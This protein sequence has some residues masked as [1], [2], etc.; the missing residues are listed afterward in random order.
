MAHG[1][2]ASWVGAALWGALL[3]L[4][5]LGIGGRAVMRVI[6]VSA[7]TPPTATFEGTLTVLLAG[8]GS[9]AAAG[10]IYRVLVALLPHRR[11]LRHLAFLLVL[12]G[13][14]LR[15]LRPIQP[16]PLALFGS[17]MAIFAAAFLATWRRV[18]LHHSPVEKSEDTARVYAR[19]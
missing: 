15:G 13:L 18:G 10:I 14:T 1:R 8:T 12:A 9:G 6:A 17:L 5:L 4:L 3:G 2:L 19:L 16:L 7:G 11:Q